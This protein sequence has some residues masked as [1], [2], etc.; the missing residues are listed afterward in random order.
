MTRARSI[1]PEVTL[2]LS[3]AGGRNALAQRAS[4]PDLSGT[5]ILDVARSDSSSFTPKSATYVVTQAADSII[6]DRE[7]SGTGK[8]HAVYALDGTPRVNTLRLIGTSTEA[9][10]KVE[11][12]GDTLVVHTTSRPEDADLVQIDRWSLGA[13]G[14]ELR[15]HREAVYAGQSMGSPTLVFGRKQ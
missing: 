12:I 6:V 1:A 14:T 8:Q 11:W 3:L 15:I 2:L 5:W 7:T 10:S 9:T 4:H 13:N